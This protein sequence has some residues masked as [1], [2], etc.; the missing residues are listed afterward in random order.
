MLFWFGLLVALV[1]GLLSIGFSREAVKLRFSVVGDYHLDVA[2]VVLVI[3]GLALPAVEHYGSATPFRTLVLTCEPTPSR[4]PTA[5][6]TATTIATHI[7]KATG[8]A[9]PKAVARG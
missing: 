1:A 5:K 3:F 6:P 7:A 9:S 4:V 8:A 2:A